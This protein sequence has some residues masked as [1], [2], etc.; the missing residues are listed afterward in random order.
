MNNA[1]GSP[2]YWVPGNYYSKAQGWPTGIEGTPPDIPAG[3]SADWTW[4][5]STQTAGQYCALVGVAHQD[6]TY[7]AQ[8]NAEGKLVETE[9][10][11]PE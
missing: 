10:V 9:I 11:P 4:Y 3:A 5:I 8:Y 2:A 6:W 7:L 1:D